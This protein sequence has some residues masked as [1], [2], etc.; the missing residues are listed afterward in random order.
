[1]VEEQEA[2]HSPWHSEAF[3]SAGR[4]IGWLKPIIFLCG[5]VSHEFQSAGRIIGWLKE[6]YLVNLARFMVVSIRRADYW[7]VEAE[8]RRYRLSDIEVSIRRADY[9][10][11]E[12]ETIACAPRS[13]EVSIRR[14]DY[15]LVEASTAP[16][17]R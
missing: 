4:I 12:V 1:M 15:W 13:G 10:L 2:R 16:H 11:V 5:C 9:W 8:G 7:L 17:A 6:Y 3:Q 14:A